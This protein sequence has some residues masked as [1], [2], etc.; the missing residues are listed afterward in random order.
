MVESEILPWG[1]KEVEVR[2]SLISFYMNDEVMW[3]DMLTQKVGRDKRT[4]DGGKYLAACHDQH[5]H[6]YWI[7]RREYGEGE[8]CPFYLERRWDFRNQ[9]REVEANS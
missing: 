7:V 3:F 4:I 1:C 8:K 5:N 9:E 2:N 6:C